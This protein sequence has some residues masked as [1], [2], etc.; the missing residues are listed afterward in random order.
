MTFFTAISRFYGKE[1]PLNKGG[2]RDRKPCIIFF[3]IYN[4]LKYNAKHLQLATDTQVNPS[5]PGDGR[6]TGGRNGRTGENA[7]CIVLNPKRTRANKRGPTAT[8]EANEAECVP[9][10][11]GQN[12]RHT[13]AQCCWDSGLEADSLPPDSGTGL[14]PNL[15]S[16]EPAVPL[17]LSRIPSATSPS[18]G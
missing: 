7:V 8:K 16:C 15:R 17:V 2:T 4:Y 6:A 12:L 13:L 5:P 3:L 10:R 14:G 11:R 9:S 18:V 1:M